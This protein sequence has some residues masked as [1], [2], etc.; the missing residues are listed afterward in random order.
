[1]TSAKNDRETWIQCDALYTPYQRQADCLIHIVQG[2]IQQMLPA[3]EMPANGRLPDGFIHIPGA[4]VAPGFVDLHVHGA[5]GCDLMDGSATTLATVSKVL[6]RYGTTSFLATTMSAS[7]TDL[8]CALRGLAPH[9]N[10]ELPGARCLGIHMEGPFLNPLRRG[11]HCAGCLRKA[12]RESFL[13]FMEWSGNRVR[14]LTIAPEMD[15]GCELVRTATALGISVSLGHSDATEAQARAAVDAGATQATHT[16]N[17]MRPFHQREPGILGVTLTDERI[18][19]EII[20]DGIHVGTGAINLLLRAKGV[21]RVALVTDGSSG[22]GMP[23]GKYPLG[24]KSIIVKDG[25]CRDAEGH[26]AGSVLT[27]DRAVRN[28]V[29]WIEVPTHEALIMATSTPARSMKMS[30]GLG[31]VHPGADADLVFLDRKLEVI[32]TMVAGRIVYQRP[33]TADDGGAKK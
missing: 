24:S 21:D 32:Q 10:E 19:A 11:T 15:P 26:L 25:E 6:A 4:L 2:K 1:M 12:D 28:V 13:R 33:D 3:S 23:D 31:T 27:M 16:Y 18:Y 5:A 22:L 30:N 7:D 14:R 17:A 20:A 8:E 29:Q 9:M